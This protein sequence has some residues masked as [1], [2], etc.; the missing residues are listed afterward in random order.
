VD[1]AGHRHGIDSAE[2]REAVFQLDA[3][4]GSLMRGL[5]SVRPEVNVVIVSDHGLAVLDRLVDLT[6]HAD[7]TGVTVVN[8]TTMIA[9]Y[10][11]D[12]TRLRKVYNSLRSRNEGSYAVYWRRE[13]P[14]HLH[15]R[16]NVRACAQAI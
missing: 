9:L 15:Y 11:A 12:K 4:I 3:T 2:M 16:R 1:T 5:E 13:M 8:T 14:E 6:D 7:Y 10:A